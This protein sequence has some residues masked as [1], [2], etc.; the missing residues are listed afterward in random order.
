MDYIK[1]FDYFNSSINIRVTN[2]QDIESNLEIHDVSGSLIENISINNNVHDFDIKWS[3]DGLPSGVYFIRLNSRNE[4]Q[5]KKVL[6]L[7]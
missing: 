4:N 1:Y 2:I 7:K 6:Y 5:L 3:A